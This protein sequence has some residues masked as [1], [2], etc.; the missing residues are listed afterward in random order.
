MAPE[1]WAGEPAD[2]A[3]DQYSFCV[4]L[5]E[6]LYGQ[7]PFA[8][9]PER[10]VSPPARTHDGRRVPA[11]LRRALEH[12]LAFEPHAR[13]ASM[14]SLLAALERWRRRSLPGSPTAWTIFGLLVIA[15]LAVF[16][17]GTQPDHRQRPT[18]STPELAAA[19]LQSLAVDFGGWSARLP[20]AHLD[21]V[22]AARARAELVTLMQTARTRDARAGF[23]DLALLLRGDMALRSRWFGARHAFDAALGSALIGR[24]PTH[25][26]V[27]GEQTHPFVQF[28]LAA[29][30]LEHARL[31]LGQ[32]Q[33]ARTR[34]IG[35]RYQRDWGQQQAS[36]RPDTLTQ[37]KFLDEA[38]IKDESDRT[39]RA[40][41]TT[42]QRSVLAV[43]DG[44]RVLTWD[45]AG[46]ASMLAEVTIPVALSNQ[47]LAQL[48]QVLRRHALALLALPIDPSAH[49]LQSVFD[50]MAASAAPHVLAMRHGQLVIRVEDALAFG[51]I[52]QRTRAALLAL[53]PAQH[54]ARPGLSAGTNIPVFYLQDGPNVEERSAPSPAEPKK[55]GPS[56]EMRVP[57]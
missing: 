8:G 6:A 34:A 12:G 56:I 3:A 23:P 55:A 22:A 50:E 46:P 39:F 9:R 19:G 33:S 14:D 16:L 37:Q 4:V 54:A 42:A 29:M 45:Q 41:L 30:Q 44:E 1:V 2:A 5:Y 26:L 20:D 38:Q 27:F 32:G 24:I 15:A 52:M 53:L 25:A 36:Y 31:P 57:Q 7:R 10:G 35:E 28:N 13:F 51:R 11:P 18:S 43:A 21:F 40:A 49:E 17:I 47:D 48:P